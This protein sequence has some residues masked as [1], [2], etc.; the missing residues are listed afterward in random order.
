M[1]AKKYLNQMKGIFVV[2]SLAALFWLYWT[3]GRTVFSLTDWDI[4]VREGVKGVFQWGIVIGYCFF[5]LC[6]VAVQMWFLI[7]QIRSLK[8]GI[9]FDKGCATI[10]FSWGILWF[11]YDFCSTNLGLMYGHQAFNT[12]TI[13]GTM[14]GIP[15][16][17]I[18]FAILY[19][20]ATEISEEQSLT[21]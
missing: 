2:A 18:T 5:S 21:I 14:V 7:R 10:I 12:I 20:M 15:M 19:R 9:M 8:K 6:L 17:A 1:N 11:L 16:V 4:E 13:D 3:I